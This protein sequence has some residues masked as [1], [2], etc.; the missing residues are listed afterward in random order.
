MADRVP[1]FSE[2][3]ALLRKPVHLAVFVNYVLSSSTP[4]TLVRRRAACCA[5]ARR[6]TSR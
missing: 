3:A 5:S 4:E 2:P 6:P 1:E